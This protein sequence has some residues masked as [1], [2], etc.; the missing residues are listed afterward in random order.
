M[1][2]S[3]GSFLN[4]AVLYLTSSS[5]VI[6]N[7]SQSDVVM[8]LFCCSCV[9]AVFL[10]WSSITTMRGLANVACR[11]YDHWKC[12]NWVSNIDQFGRSD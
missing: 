6:L 11:G 10:L 5:I 4:A 7:H 12:P 1:K 9:A 2:Y 8:L 3:A